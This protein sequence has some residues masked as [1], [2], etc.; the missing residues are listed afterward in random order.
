MGFILIVSGIFLRELS[1]WVLGKHFTVRVQVRDKAKLV[2]QGP[3]K[4]I[5]HP[6]YTGGF[7]TFVGIPLT[8]ELGQ[9]HLSRL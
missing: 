2:T 7:L 1:I 6:A 9:V 5:R 4:Y 3:Y 8:I